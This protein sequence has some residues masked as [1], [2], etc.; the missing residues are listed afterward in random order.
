MFWKVTWLEIW[1]LRYWCTG[2][3]AEDRKTGVCKGAMAV[4]EAETGVEDI[5]EIEDVEQIEV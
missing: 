5:E 4:H 2:T 3:S 1:A